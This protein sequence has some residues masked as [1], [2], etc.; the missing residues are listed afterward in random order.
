M[1]Y[2]GCIEKEELVEKLCDSRAEGKADPSIIDMYNKQRMEI[3]LD[4][5]EIGNVAEI[6]DENAV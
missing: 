6:R 2:T 3:S 4:S 1:D 5:D